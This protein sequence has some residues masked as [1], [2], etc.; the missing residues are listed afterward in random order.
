MTLGPWTNDLRSRDQHQH[1]HEDESRWPSRRSWPTGQAV[2][3]PR[4]RGSA[5]AGRMLVTPWGRRTACSCRCT[6]RSSCTGRKSMPIAQGV[7]HE[8]QPSCGRSAGCSRRRSLHFRRGVRIRVQ[9]EEERSRTGTRR[10]YLHRSTAVALLGPWRQLWE[11]NR[12]RNLAG[13]CQK[14]NLV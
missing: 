12:E 8:L 11:R 14:L 6:G 13:E 1:Q 3:F 2:G 7:A 10:G 4:L 9:V 5:P